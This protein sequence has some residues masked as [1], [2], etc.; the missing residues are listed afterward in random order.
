MI[1]IELINKEIK[2]EICP[3]TLE[4]I[5]AMHVQGFTHKHTHTHTHTHTHIYIF[6]NLLLVISR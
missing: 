6:S 1:Y 2:V 3:H 4:N 5:Q